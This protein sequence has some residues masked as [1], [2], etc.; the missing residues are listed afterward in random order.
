MRGGLP[1]LV[2]WTRRAGTIDFCLALAALVS[3]VHNIIFHFISPYRPATWTGRRAGS[4][5]SVSL[6]KMDRGKVRLAKEKKKINK[7]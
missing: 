4:P 3:S 6:G 5:V 7:K 2:S 1:W